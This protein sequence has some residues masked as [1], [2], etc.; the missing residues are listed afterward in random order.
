MNKSKKITKTPEKN[1]QLSNA[2]GYDTDRMLF[3]EP[4]TSNVPGNAVPP[5]TY[6]RINISTTN[7]D[8]SVGEL[9]FSTSK[10]FSFGVSENRDQKTNE[11]T[12]YVLPL[13]LYTRKENGGP[14]NDETA[15]VETFESV[16]KKCKN[17][18]YDNREELDKYDLDRAELKGMD[19]V[20]YWKKDKGKVV[21]G[22][23][24]TLY[25]KLISMKKDNKIISMFFNTKGVSVDPMTIVGT[26]CLVTAAIKVESIFI[27]SKISLQVKLY[28]ATVELLENSMKPLLSRESTG[29]QRILASNSNG[30][31]VMMQDDDGGDAGSIKDEEEQEEVKPTPPKEEKVVKKVKKIVKA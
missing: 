30:G 22:T 21:E 5:V 19:K 28:E 12:G 16:I 6:K 27:G 20:L 14:L 1:T 23:G 15:W 24:P 3:S 4:I 29:P 2:V 8:G 13:C 7:S 31:N 10:L 11:V 25:P 26:R 9:V 18:V 17:H